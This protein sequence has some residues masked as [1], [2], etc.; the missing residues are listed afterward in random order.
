MARGGQSEQPH[1]GPEMGPIPNTVI[2]SD[3]I[4]GDGWITSQA[5]APLPLG[6][7]DGVS[8]A[9]APSSGGGE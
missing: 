9:G 5:A 2:F 8:V 4:E 7:G 1:D 6:P 3:E